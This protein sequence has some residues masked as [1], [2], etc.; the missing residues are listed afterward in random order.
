MIRVEA[1]LVVDF[2][3]GFVAQNV[4]GFLDFLEALF[5]RFVTRDLNPDGTCAPGGGKPSGSRPCRPSEAH[6]TFR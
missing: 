6:S 5:R 2:A 3:L 1:V 4:I